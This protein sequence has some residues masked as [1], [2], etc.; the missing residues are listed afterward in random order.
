MDIINKKINHIIQDDR[1]PF[2]LLFININLIAFVIV[3]FIVNNNLR[4]VIRTIILIPAI[5]TFA[6]AI[7]S[8]NR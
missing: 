5:I 8:S 6:L 4:I 7:Y 2:I 1:L 3:G